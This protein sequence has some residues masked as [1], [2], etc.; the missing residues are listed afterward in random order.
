MNS[1]IL[2]GSNVLK[3]EAER[4]MYD[5]HFVREIQDYEVLKKLEPYKGFDSRSI[6]FTDKQEQILKTELRCIY[7]KNDPCWGYND[8]KK[9]IVS[10]CINGDCPKIKECNQDYSK[11]NARYWQTDKAERTLYG[12]PNKQTEYYFVDM[13]SEAEMKLYDV[14]PQNDGLEYPTIKNA[15]IPDEKKKQAPKTRID[16]VTGR[17]QVVIGKRWQITDNSD[18]QGE[19]IVDIWG[20]VDDVTERR[21]KRPKKARMLEKIVP[22]KFTAKEAI[23]APVDVIDIDYANKD[24]YEKKVADLVMEEVKLTEIGERFYGDSTWL[25]VLA[26]PAEKAY[27]SSMLLMDE[28]EHGFTTK[29]MIQLVHIG[30]LREVSASS[31]FVSENVLKAGCLEN[32][33]Q[34]WKKL[35]TVPRI[36]QLDITDR[37]YFNFKYRDGL[38]RWTCR[39]M[40]GV[41]HVCVEDADV[42]EIDAEDGLYSVSLVEDKNSYMILKK[43]GMPLGRLGASFT[44]VINALKEAK[45]IESSPAVVKGISIDVK[46]GKATVLGMGHLKFIEY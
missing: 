15:V 16:P 45:E 29:D 43:D 27:V 5:S 20:F 40:Y 2:I 34:G 38:N 22:P 4:P 7:A 30:E 31:V 46:Q 36:L 26:N 32:D 10:A 6:H 44:D 14:E 24:V 33:T 8:Q 1:N 17:K 23:S 18:Y 9:K 3:F 12:N 35:T 21:E 13:I 39:N 25:I 11:E 42:T 19:E 28:L 41:T 37:D